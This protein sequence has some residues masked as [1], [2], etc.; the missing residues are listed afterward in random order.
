ME[1]ETVRENAICF[2]TNFGILLGIAVG[3]DEPRGR[4]RSI[5]GL[6]LHSYSRTT[7]VIISYKRKGRRERLEPEVDVA[8]GHARQL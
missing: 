4:C 1:T 7:L 5:N 8:V 6:A 3:R 2:L